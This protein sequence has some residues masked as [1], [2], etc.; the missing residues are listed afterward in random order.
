MPAQ[1]AVTSVPATTLAAMRRAWRPMVQPR[2]IT[3]PNRTGVLGCHA[4]IS[5]AALKER[6][7]LRG[8]KLGFASATSAAAPATCGATPTC[9][10]THRLRPTGPAQLPVPKT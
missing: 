7:D 6:L 2:A 9:Q 10:Q 1:V 3:S 4:E 5:C 8:E